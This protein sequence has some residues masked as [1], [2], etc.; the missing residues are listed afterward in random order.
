MSQSSM[1]RIGRKGLAHGRM[2]ARRLRPRTPADPAPVRREPAMGEL[3]AV[4][5]SQTL[6]GWLNPPASLMTMHLLSLLPFGPVVEIGVYRGKYLSILRA[7]MGSSCRIVGYDIFDQAQAPMI[8]RELTAAFGTLGDIALIQT[9]STRLTPA[10][11]AADCGG[12]PVFMSID[13]SHEA[14]PVL[15]DLTLADAV[16]DPAGMVAMDDVLNPLAL[17]V[18]EGLGRFLALPDADLVPFAYAANKMFLCR[19]DR[20]AANLAA[21]IAFVEGRPAD[22]SFPL[23]AQMKAQND[24]SCR[25]YYGFDVLIATG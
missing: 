2:M 4:T 3:A 10:R 12:A 22:P 13:G 20:Q 21:A 1:I 6:P 7:T 11:V 14:T 5:L 16:L 19:P 8:E 25:H 23:Y 18:N 24:S 9:D 17:G 15:S